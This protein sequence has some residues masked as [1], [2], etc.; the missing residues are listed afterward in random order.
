MDNKSPEKVQKFTIYGQKKDRKMAAATS[1][2]HANGAY[3][4]ALWISSVQKKNSFLVNFWCSFGAVLFFDI[5]DI[6]KGLPTMR[7]VLNKQICA[8]GESNSQPA[9]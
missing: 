9:D 2:T 3:L 4:Q 1:L 8:L 7:K 5:M 6:K